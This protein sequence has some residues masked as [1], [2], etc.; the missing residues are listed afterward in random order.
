MTAR[1][2]MAT[3]STAGRVEPK[4]ERYS[5]GGNYCSV[6]DKHDQWCE[7]IQPPEPAA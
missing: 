4:P 7:H 1:A 5:P 2:F 3:L 6:C